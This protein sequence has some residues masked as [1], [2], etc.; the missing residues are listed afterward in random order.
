MDVANWF[1][2]LLVIAGLVDMFVIL[3]MTEGAEGQN[4]VMLRMVRVLKCV[5]AIRLVRTFRFFRGLRLLVKACYCFLPSL[6]WSM[7][8]LL[9]FMW[10]GTLVLG[11]LLQDFITDTNNNF[12]DR[13][14]IWNRYGTAYR[15]MYTLY[16]TLSLKLV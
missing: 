1:D 12:D 16:E 13:V 11:N 15:A 2:T 8:L 7:V 5:R 14:W 10:M 6:G 4:I 3:P 9:V